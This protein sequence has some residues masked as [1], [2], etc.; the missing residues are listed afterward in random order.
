MELQYTY[1]YIKIFADTSETA[2]PLTTFLG[3]NWPDL[4]HNIICIN[5][6]NNEYYSKRL[7]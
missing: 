5:E 6:V 4:L 7:T 1:F 2:A 3:A